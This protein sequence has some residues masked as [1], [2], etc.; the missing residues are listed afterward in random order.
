MPGTVQP[1]EISVAQHRGYSPPD[2]RRSRMTATGSVTTMPKP[3]RM[4]AIRRSRIEADSPF[5]APELSWEMIS[6]RALMVVRGTTESRP[7]LGRQS[8]VGSLQKPTVL[9]THPKT[10]DCFG[11]CVPIPSHPPT[12]SAY[13]PPTSCGRFR[14]LEVRQRRQ[15]RPCFHSTDGGRRDAS[16]ERDVT[17]GE[18]LAAQ[19]H[20][21]VCRRRIVNG[22]HRLG[23]LRSWPR[24]TLR[25][26]RS[27]QRAKILR[28]VP[29]LSNRCPNDRQ[30]H[31]TQR[32]HKAHERTASRAPLQ[33]SARRA[34]HLNQIA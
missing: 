17:V 24:G 10:S 5:A 23:P 16:L 26:K 28:D 9:T 27:T 29:L 1:A 3:A 25:S 11:V 15:S 31:P 33:Q 12:A 19:S 8:H 7:H 4:S 6:Q 30:R 21:A 13:V 20:N 22:R 14:R 2:T 18:A 34:L 32:R